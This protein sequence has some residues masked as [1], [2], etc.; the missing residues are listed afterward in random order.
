MEKVHKVKSLDE[1]VILS[2]FSAK[3]CWLLL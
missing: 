3:A 2:Y 1:F